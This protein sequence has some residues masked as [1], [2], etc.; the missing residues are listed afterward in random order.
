VRIP[1]IVLTAAFGLALLP[2]SGRAQSTWSS[3]ATFASS[4]VWRGITTTNRPVI[5]P[6]I[7][8][9]VP[10]R[11]TTVS[12]GAW[13]SV[14]PARYNGPSDISAVYG[15]LPGPAFTQYSAWAHI[16]A[17]L[18]GISLSGGAETFLYPSVA[19]LAADYNTVELTVSASLALPLEPTVTAWYDVGAIRGAY[20][21][22]SLWFEQ[23]L[24]GQALSF[25]LTGGINTG[26]GPDRNENNQAYFARRGF[27]HVEF[28]ASTDYQVGG[29]TL[30]PSAHVIHGV[31]P[32]VRI[33]AP[34]RQRSTKLWIGTAI[35]WRSG[36]ED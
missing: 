23:Q 20:F 33:V 6:E 34:D 22:T 1:A 10:F 19:D 17:E 32:W 12:L 3:T 18:P 15:L 25:S 9:D 13:A 8:L 28:V 36:G 31:D 35:S 5:Q 16:A 14:E 4:Y 7:G 30:S 24:R 21:E 11:G 26:Q 2:L 27:T 29:L